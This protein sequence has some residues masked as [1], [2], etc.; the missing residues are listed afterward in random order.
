MD[1]HVH[2]LFTEV[3]HPFGFDHCCSLVLTLGFLLLVDVVLLDSVQGD[4]LIGLDFVAR[5][6]DHECVGTLVVSHWSR[7]QE[8]VELDLE[9][10][11]ILL[12][13]EKCAV[14]RLNTDDR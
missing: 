4:I 5:V 12:N 1:A 6:A 14:Y 13:E 2:G 7:Y 9:K 3:G 8:V 10:L 11:D